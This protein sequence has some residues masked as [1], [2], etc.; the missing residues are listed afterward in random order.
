MIKLYIFIMVAILFIAIPFDSEPSVKQVSLQE[1]L[2][3]VAHQHK[4]NPKLVRAFFKVESNNRFH[5]INK[6][7]KDY[8]IGQINITNIKKLGLDKNRL[9][10]D[11]LYSIKASVSIMA[12][13]KNLYE[14]KLG[15]KWVAKYNCGVKRG[16]E[17]T[18][19]S[20]KYIK[21]IYASL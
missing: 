3:I 8:G 7:S 1:A 5:A 12:F 14:K 16:C 13:F 2:D 15:K 10:T 17:N 21:K 18:R 20:K 4:I 9:L 6:R 19:K 11:K